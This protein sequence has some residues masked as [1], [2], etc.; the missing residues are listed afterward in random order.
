M[1]TDHK[2]YVIKET[3]IGGS[4]RKENHTTR[5]FCNAE[6][7]NSRA[8]SHRP[9]AKTVTPVKMLASIAGVFRLVVLS[10]YSG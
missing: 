10:L 6:H 9:N 1:A 8:P 4:Q 5:F 3:E 2:I 7:L